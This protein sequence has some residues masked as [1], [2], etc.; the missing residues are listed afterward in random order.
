MFCVYIG[1]AVDHGTLCDPEYIF[2]PYLFA[3]NIF[4]FDFL[5]DII[6]CEIALKYHDDFEGLGSSL[7]VIH[8]A[9][10]AKRRQRAAKCT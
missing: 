9:V 3:H 8:S 6:P 5:S 4:F 7:Q 1:F 10:K 2:I